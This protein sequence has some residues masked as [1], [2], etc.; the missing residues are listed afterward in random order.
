MTCHR[1]DAVLADD[2]GAPVQF[3]REN[4]YAA[5][6]WTIHWAPCELV[7]TAPHSFVAGCFAEGGDMDEPT[8][9]VPDWLT[10]DLLIIA[11]GLTTILIGVWIV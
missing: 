8:K 5:A 9:L 7:H 10:I 4:T 6:R 3:P 11:L 2:P 1:S